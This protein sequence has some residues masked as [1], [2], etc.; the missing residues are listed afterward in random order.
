MDFQLTIINVPRCWIG[1]RLSSLL[2]LFVGHYR[3]QGGNLTIGRKCPKHCPSLAARLPGS[4]LSPKNKL[5]DW[6]RGSRALLSHQRQTIGPWEDQRR[7]TNSLPVAGTRTR[8]RKLMCRRKVPRQRVVLITNWFTY[9]VASMVGH[10][11]IVNC[12][13]LSLSINLI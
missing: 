2:E 6:A 9:K 5:V 11:D 13:R 4:L 3:S 7:T 10:Y 1:Y 12:G 8:S